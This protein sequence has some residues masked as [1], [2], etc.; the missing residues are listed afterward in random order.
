LDLEEI[1]KANKDK[2]YNLALHYVQNVEDA[3]EITQD[4]FVSVYRSINTFNNNSK[5]STWIYQITINKA[6][7]YIRSKNRKKRYSQFTA[8]ILGKGESRELEPV[9]FDHPG[10]L[11]EQKE[12]MARIFHCINQLPKNQ[13][14]VLILSKIEGKSQK[15]T[16]EIMNISPKAVES[17][18]QRAKSKLLFNLNEGNEK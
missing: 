14:T 17:L 2:V 9:V 16:A 10:V 11:L 13:K 8:F 7:D 5:I 4:V 3:E 18:V 1:Y 12:N 15:E 6:L